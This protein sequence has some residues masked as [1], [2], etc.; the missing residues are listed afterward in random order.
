[1]LTVTSQAV[2]DIIVTTPKSQMQEAANEAADCLR[3]GSGSYFRRFATRPHG[4]SKGSRIFYVEDGYVRGF[5]TV[6]E[7]EEGNK[8]CET[9]GKQWGDGVYAIIPA[10]SWKWIKP[11]SMKGF[12]GWRYY[13]GEAEVIGDWKDSKPGV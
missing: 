5:G 2:R 11:V 12:Q 9:T 1:M 13:S 3:A 7:V 4:L 8:R 6:S 10:D